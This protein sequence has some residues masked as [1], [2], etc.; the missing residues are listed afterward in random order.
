MWNGK[1]TPQAT[2]WKYIT[3]TINAQIIGKLYAGQWLFMPW[4]Q[5]DVAADIEIAATNW[6]AT[7]GDI[8]VEYCLF[9]EDSKI[10]AD[11]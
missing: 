3:V 5:T 11:A 1:Y 7:T 6:S 9:H 8:P 10:L 4:S 2:I